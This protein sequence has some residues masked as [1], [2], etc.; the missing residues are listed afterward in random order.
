MSIYEVCSLALELLVV[1]IL[2]AEY[3][4]DKNLNEHVK[5]IKR[6]TKRRYDFEQLNTGESK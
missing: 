1:V 2:V 3:I 5:S 6:R 4:Y